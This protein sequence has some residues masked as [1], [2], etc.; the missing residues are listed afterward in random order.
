MSAARLS[1]S[2]G[3]YRRSA[4]TARSWPGS[5]DSV[6]AYFAVIEEHPNLYWLLARHADADGAGPDL[7][8]PHKEVIATTLTAAIGDLLRAFDL[9]SGAAEPWGFR[10]H[11]DG[12]EHRRLVAAAALHEPGPRRGICHP[13]D[14]GGAVRALA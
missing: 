5:G 7:T 4:R 1:C 8:E 13:A 11:R 14:L 6:G 3:C 12:A 2:T 10:H 9:D